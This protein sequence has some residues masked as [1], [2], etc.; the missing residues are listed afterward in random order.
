[1]T[2]C[3]EP[4][5]S[6]M[7]PRVQR[8]TGMVNSR[9]ACVGW[10]DKPQSELSRSQSSSKVDFRRRLTE[11]FHPSQHIPLLVIDP[12]SNICLAGGW[13]RFLEHCVG[14]ERHRLVLL[15]P[16]VGGVHKR[17]GPLEATTTSNARVYQRRAVREGGLGRREHGERG[18]N[19]G[20]G[21]Q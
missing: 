3:T 15:L 21:G 1:M 14:R 11:A 19:T 20:G 4:S 9:V 17:H 18:G 13:H 2:V 7:T 8:H 5:T 12:G 10:E 16:M 6:S